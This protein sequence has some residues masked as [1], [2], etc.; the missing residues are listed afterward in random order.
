MLPNT[1]PAPFPGAR[2]IDQVG[3]LV[4][5]LEASIHRYMRLWPLS[6]WHVYTYGPETVPQLTYRGQ[7]AAYSMRLAL[8]TVATPQI[9][10]IQPLEGPSIY[11][12]WLDAH[13][14]GMHHVGLVVDSLDEAIEQMQANGYALLQSGRGYGLESEGGFAYFDTEAEFG[15]VLEAIMRPA[16]RQPPEAVLSPASAA[17]APSGLASRASRYT[18]RFNPPRT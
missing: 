13:G 15:L 16:R 1:L 7:P 6:E 17:S 12:E 10:L 18:A 4:E 11:R 5:D 14:E 9:E 8:T 2:P 3:I